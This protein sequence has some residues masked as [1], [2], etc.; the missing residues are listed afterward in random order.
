MK[1]EPKVPLFWICFILTTVGFL[2]SSIAMIMPYWY[3]RYPQ[4]HSR[5]VSLGLW[6]VCFEGYMSK[7]IGNCMYFGCFYLFDVKIA[8]LWS[9]IFRA[10]FVACQASYIC[11]FS[12]YIL[13][14]CIIT[15]QAVKLI[16]FRG[17]R[18]VLFIMVALSLSSV[19]TLVSL[20]TMGVGVDTEQ[21]IEKAVK[22]PWL[23]D[24]SQNSLS[25]SYGLAAVSMLPSWIT[26]I[27]LGWFVYPKRS[28]CGLLS[29][30]AW[31]WPTVDDLQCR[32]HV[33][34]LQTVKLSSYSNPQ[35]SFN[36]TTVSGDQH[37]YSYPPRSIITT[38]QTTIDH[39][40]ELDNNINNNNILRKPTL[41]H[42]SHAQPVLLAMKTTTQQDQG[43]IS[44]AGGKLSNYDPRS[45]DTVSLS[46]YEQ[47]PFGVLYKQ[48]NIRTEDVNSTESVKGSS[49]IRSNYS[50]RSNRSK[51]SSLSSISSSFRNYKS[52][53]WPSI[54]EC[55]D[56]QQLKHHQQRQS[57][58]NPKSHLPL[59]AIETDKSLITEQTLF[60]N[61][62]TSVW[63]ENV[64]YEK[65]I[66]H[67]SIIQAARPLKKSRKKR[68]NQW[69][70]NL[71]PFKEDTLN[72]SPFSTTVN[73]NSTPS[74]FVQVAKPL[75]R[76]R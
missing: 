8:P 16:S 60:N 19:L 69:I 44:D 37:P 36:I 53:L 59:L 15:S 25:W 74:T 70:Q 51:L 23:E 28:P 17:S 54:K 63:T 18:A 73:N 24:L 42:K 2:C 32:Y 14:E 55:V 9:I 50:I 13:A 61:P 38:N 33:K 5:F 11:G 3:A 58:L 39:W 57:T 27:L 30:S 76:K 47:I 66:V 29:I 35:S 31:E 43:C 48:P 26:V 40:T 34:D 71:A 6:E 46:S 7:R 67:N 21:K 75:I 62:D 49:F 45:A 10:W 72:F 52:S 64:I 20:I 56:E 41:F 1:R 68:N 12:T 65:P 22:N 4:S